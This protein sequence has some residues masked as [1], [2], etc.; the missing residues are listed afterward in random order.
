[1][2]NNRKHDVELST[3]DDDVEPSGELENLKAQLEEA[4]A[5]EDFDKA[6]ELQEQIEYIEQRIVL[7]T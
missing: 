1:M 4:V 6:A 7:Y 5:D 2:N 3:E